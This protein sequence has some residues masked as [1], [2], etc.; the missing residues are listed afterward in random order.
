MECHLCT[1]STHSKCCSRIWNF[2]FLYPI[3]PTCSSCTDR[4]R[5]NWTERV[6]APFKFGILDLLPSLAKFG[7]ALTVSAVGRRAAEKLASQLVRQHLR[8]QAVTQAVT[9]SASRGAGVALA[10]W[11]KQAALQAAQKGLTTATARYSA[12]QG[13]LA[14]LGPVMWSWLAVDLALAS[15]GTDYARVIKAV[16]VLAQVRLV[17][18]H[19]FVQADGLGGESVDHTGMEF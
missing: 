5:G 1:I 10:Q 3:C 9:G 4:P 19:G 16:F 6:T 17:R 8:Y 18:T 2:T 13:A 7:S 11:Q 14:F 15:L 12:V